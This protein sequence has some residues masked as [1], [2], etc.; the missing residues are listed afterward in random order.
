MVEAHDCDWS[1]HY[2]GMDN[3][4]SHHQGHYAEGEVENGDSSVGQLSASHTNPEF[5]V[6][7]SGVLCA[8]LII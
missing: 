3:G 2:P 6:L 4:H 1:A 8:M 5:S 7:I